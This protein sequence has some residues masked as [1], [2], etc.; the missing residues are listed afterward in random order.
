MKHLFLNINFMNYNILSYAIYVPVTLGLTIWVASTLFRN[1]RIF[2]VEIFHGDKLL[3]DSVNKLLVVGFYLI[4]LGYAIYTLQI[5]GDISSVQVVIEK[6]STK[7][8]AIIMILGLMHFF[9]LY[10]LF[11]LRSK[12]T[13]ERKLAA[14]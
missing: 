10:V 12:A 3:A 9:N 11:R 13:G 7:I 8:G 6:L 2:L 14:S 5:I 1:G 4:N